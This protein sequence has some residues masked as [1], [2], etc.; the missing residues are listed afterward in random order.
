VR[1]R[2]GRILRHSNRRRNREVV[3]SYERSAGIAIGALLLVV[4]T[5][6]SVWRRQGDQN[7]PKS[8]KSA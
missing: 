5:A 1:S 3:M 7:S 6:G 2:D 8:W 4:D